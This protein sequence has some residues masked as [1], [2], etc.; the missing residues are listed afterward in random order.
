MFSLKEYNMSI[1]EFTVSL[2]NPNESPDITISFTDGTIHQ[3]IG[4]SL[5]VGK[6]MHIPEGAT[7]LNNCKTETR[8]IFKFGLSV[9]SNWKEEKIAGID[10]KLYYNKK[11]FVYKFPT[12]DII[13]HNIR[14]IDLLVKSINDNENTKFCYSTN[15]GN[16]IDTSRENCFRTGR[17]I[18]YTL[19][20][21]N[22]LIIGKNYFSDTENYYISIK[23]FDEEDRKNCKR[24]K[25]LSDLVQNT[26]AYEIR[27]RIIRAYEEG[28]KFRVMVF[29]PLLPGFAGEPE[30][31]G[32]LQI[33]LK[34]TYAAI[35]R[36][37]GTS[38]IEKLRE[39]MGEDWK[40]YIGFYSLR[41]HG[42]VN[43]IPT[44]EIIYIHSKL[45]IVD[46]KKVIIGSANIN[47]RSMLGDRDS[48]FCV[49]IHEEEK[50]SYFMDGK[51]TSSA[52]F[53]YSLRTHLMA[54][55][56]GLDPKDE[57]LFDPLKDELWSLLMDTAKNNTEIYRDLFYCYPDDLMR[58]FDEVLKMKRPNKLDDIELNKL[59]DSYNKEKDNIKGHVVEFPLHF[60]EDE[61]LGIPFFSLENAIP[62][63]S[64]I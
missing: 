13:K 44:T 2:Y 53:A 58:T 3:Y 12:S 55:H 61:V 52:N 16:A 59:K 6:I 51:R 40:K 30:E 20:F 33:I 41:N 25:L 11:S 60:L 63:K 38:I 54:E 43:G 4:N 8:F 9:E 47:D 57:I 36:N 64:Y 37:Y 27:Q 21:I 50:R 10:G 14:T 39:V 48:E 28:K 35:C 22:P 29:I 49:L 31:S 32:T 62:E 23:P 56:M 5:Q 19:S 26:I 15:L 34:Y 45:M 24:K 46:D 7:I 42:L 1:F 18:P 17:Y